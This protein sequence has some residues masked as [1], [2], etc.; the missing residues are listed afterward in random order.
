MPFLVPE[1]GYTPK[2][3]EQLDQTASWGSQVW[4]SDWYYGHKVFLLAHKLM[5]QTS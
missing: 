3:S 5:A 2:G 1:A 4:L